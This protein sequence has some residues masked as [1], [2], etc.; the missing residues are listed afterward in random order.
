MLS[1]RATRCPHDCE[2]SPNSEMLAS[3]Y[4]KPAIEPTWGRLVINSRALHVLEL[5]LLRD[6]MGTANPPSLRLLTLPCPAPQPGGAPRLSY[7]LETLQ[8]ISNTGC[9]PS[10]TNQTSPECHGRHM[11]R[12]TGTRGKT[13]GLLSLVTWRRTRRGG[14]LPPRFPRV[15]LSTGCT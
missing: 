9:R 2:T 4:L 14:S 13:L 8:G 5:Y 11:P 6:G 1:S 7:Q 15:S 10:G 12:S 3:W